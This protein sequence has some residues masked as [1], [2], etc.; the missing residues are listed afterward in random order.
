MSIVRIEDIPQTWSDTRD[1][2]FFSIVARLFSAEFSFGAGVLLA[3]N[4]DLG[5]SANVEHGGSAI[6]SGM[7][8][9]GNVASAR[10]PAMPTT[11]R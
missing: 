3:G 9:P 8:V 1:V 5:E 6:S 2:P 4:S 10:A 11:S 7:V